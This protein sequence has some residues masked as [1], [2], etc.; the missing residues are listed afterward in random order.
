MRIQSTVGSAVLALAAVTA[1]RPAATTVTFSRD[2]RP[3]LQSHCTVCH[4][5]GGPS[6]MPLVAYDEVLPW[7]QTIK[8]QALAR[9]MPIW[10]AARGYGAFSNDPTL[11]PHELALIVAWA[12]GETAT[13]AR[14]G[15]GARGGVGAA[16]AV[17]AAGAG[18]AGEGGAGG[19]G[20]R[21]AEVS[22]ES[23]PSMTVRVR[24]GWI[25]GWT[26][27]P[28]DPLIASATFTAGD[29][30][31]IGAW[32]AGDRAARLPRGAAIRVV[33]PVHVHIRRREKT[34]YEAAFTPRPSSLQFSWLPSTGSP[35]P[36]PP[37]RRV[38]IERVACGGTIGPSD[39]SLIGVRPLL[40]AGA[41]AQVTVERIGGAQPAL[42]GWFREFDP[43][44]QRI[45]WLD[46]PLD[47]VANA[48]LTSDAPCQLD[49]VLSA[50]R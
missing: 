15:G 19:A 11:T 37:E 45:Y 21:G 1:G 16:G 34:S 10:H 33:S 4:S 29:G 5:S 20:A 6:P 3:I 9:R 42:L 38:R 30:S 14:G 46:R 41:S 2:I 35:P 12:D 27:V 8:Q 31:T 49:V 13:D 36:R 23:D 26:F 47:F 50:R 44:Y 18:G 48:R 7:A 40:A 17:R 24:N 43:N 25:T 22:A 39:A 32:T 28:G